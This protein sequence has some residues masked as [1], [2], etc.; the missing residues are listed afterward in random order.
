MGMPIL[1]ERSRAAVSAPRRAERKT[2]L[3]ELFAIM[4]MRIGLAPAP[5]A[6]EGDA[7]DGAGA[8]GVDFWHPAVSRPA[9]A[10]ATMPKRAVIGALGAL[11]VLGVLALTVRTLRGRRMSVRPFGQPARREAGARLIENDGHDDGTSDDDPFVVLIGMQCADGLP[12]EDDEDGPQHRVDGTPAT[13]AQ[14]SAA[15][16]RGSDDV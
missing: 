10:A 3:V 5:G 11:G 9:R 16:D 4:A 13:A 12:N 1:L 6:S 7:A 15:N 8:V 2:G 14:T